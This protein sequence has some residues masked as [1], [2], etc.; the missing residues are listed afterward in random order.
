MGIYELSQ[1]HRGGFEM[2]I[3]FAFGFL[4]GTLFILAIVNL[5]EL[6]K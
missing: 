2:M 5:L 6:M 4:A 3:A 1:H